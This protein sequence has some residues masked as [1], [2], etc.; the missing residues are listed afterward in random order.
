M[1][2]DSLRLLI[3]SGI[4]DFGGISPVTPDYINPLHPWPHLERLREGCEGLGFTL[5]ARLAAYPRHLDDPRFVAP[6]MVTHIEDARARVA[7]SRW[8]TLV[9]PEFGCEV[10]E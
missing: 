9:A 8:N 3:D 6:S 10:A 2:A 7:N 5:R 1:N 4:N